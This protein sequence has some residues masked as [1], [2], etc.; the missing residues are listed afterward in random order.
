MRAFLMARIET[1][2]L[3]YVSACMRL[4]IEEGQQNNQQL[5]KGEEL[6]MVHIS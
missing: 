4:C 3:M 5:R 6:D 1:L 2:L